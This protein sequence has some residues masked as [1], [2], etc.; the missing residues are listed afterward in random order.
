[1]IDEVWDYLRDY[2]FTKEELN[3][4]E[5]Q[6]PKMFEVD[7]QTIKN[8]LLMLENFNLT[9]REVLT[10]VR[11][12]FYMLTVTKNKVDYLNEIYLIRLGYDDKEMRRLLLTHPDAYIDNPEKVEQVLDFLETKEPKAK[13]KKIILEKPELLDYEITE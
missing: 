6:N 1:M 9:Q 4:F 11:K 12:N 10:L 7:L 2:G 5:K 3:S 8:N 13:I